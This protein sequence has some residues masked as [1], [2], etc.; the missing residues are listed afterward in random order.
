MIPDER[1]A[2]SA[3]IENS[4]MWRS[5]CRGHAGRSRKRAKSAGH[6]AGW[7]ALMLAGG[8][9]KDRNA[10]GCG[11][12][13]N[14]R[15]HD[16]ARRHDMVR[17]DNCREALRQHAKLALVR[18]VRRLSRLAVITGMTD[19]ERIGG[20]HLAHR[21]RAEQRLKGERIGRDHRDPRLPY[22]S[23]APERHARLPHS[24][25]ATYPRRAPARKR[26]TSGS[27][28]R[29]LRPRVTGRILSGCRWRS[30]SGS[31]GRP[32]PARRRS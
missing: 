18:A 1:S 9:T 32:A 21:H 24:P 30:L 11:N 28:L 10:H 25:A 12:A 19:D 22:P 20:G 16:S 3:R 8:R 7:S 6:H 14:R 23:L 5:A 31:S 15:K 4:G 17:P 27:A 29:V 13:F 2:R 26:L